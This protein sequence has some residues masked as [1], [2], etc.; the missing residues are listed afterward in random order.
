MIIFVAWQQGRGSRLYNLYNCLCISVTKD[1]FSCR[2]IKGRHRAR[3]KKLTLISRALLNDNI[4]AKYSPPQN[5]KSV[6]STTSSSSARYQP[7]AKTLPGGVVVVGGASANRSR[8]SSASR[9]PRRKKP[10]D[11]IPM[12]AGENQPELLS[13]GNEIATTSF[14]IDKGSVF[15][16]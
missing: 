2:L 1:T 7:I 16:V 4:S 15:D 8:P 14:C 6:N 12:D 3:E 5:L 11:V 13:P 10:E 9:S